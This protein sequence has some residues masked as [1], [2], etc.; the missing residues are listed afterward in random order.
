M[1]AMYLFKN[2]QPPLPKA[3]ELGSRLLAGALDGSLRPGAMV[4]PKPWWSRLWEVLW[5]ST[6]TPSPIQT[7][8]QEKR[9]EVYQ[10]VLSRITN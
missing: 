2:S 9:H 5:N 10:Y 8:N 3:A 7:L 4:S 1:F 6:P